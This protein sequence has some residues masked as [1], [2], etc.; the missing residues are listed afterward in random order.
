MHTVNNCKDIDECKLKMSNCAE[1][2][3][4]INTMGSYKCQCKNG[5]QGNGMICKGGFYIQFN[6]NWTC[7]MTL[8][9]D[10]DIDECYTGLHN[11]DK[12]ANCTNNEGSF[13]CTCKESFYGNGTDCNGKNSYL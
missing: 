4:C 12:N 7:I 6:T 5:F 10:L 2:A 11:C 1:N 8:K 13:T 3:D 9:I